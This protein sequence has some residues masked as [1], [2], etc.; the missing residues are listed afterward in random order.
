MKRMNRWTKN[1]QGECLV[2]MQSKSKALNVAEFQ[3]EQKIMWAVRFDMGLNEG[4]K[5]CG[6]LV[7]CQGT[8]VTLVDVLLEI[9][10]KTGHEKIDQ[11]VL[12]GLYQAWRRAR[13]YHLAK[14]QQNEGQEV[15]R[16]MKEWVNMVVQVA[17][18][19]REVWEEVKGK[20][21]QKLAGQNNGSQTCVH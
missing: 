13:E 2:Q 1:G 10:R 11:K 18:C 5:W 20:K 7:S 3:K 12:P 4:G 14:R 6:Q 17:K 16:M 9:A 21:E 15:L 19:G 8:F